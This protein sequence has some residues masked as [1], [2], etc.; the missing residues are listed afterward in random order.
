MLTGKLPFKGDYE[1]AIIYSILNEEP[2]L[3]EEILKSCP[4]PLIRLLEKSLRKDISL[5]TAS[6]SEFKTELEQ[7]NVQTTGIGIKRT[8][9]VNRYFKPAILIPL[10]IIIIIGTAFILRELYRLNKIRWAR[11]EALPKIEELVNMGGPGE[12]FI[13]AFDLAVKAEEFIPNDPKLKQHMKWISGV[14]SIQTQP[15]GARILR[16]PFDK[17]EDDWEFIGLSPVDS[18]R[19]PSYLFRWKFE[20]SGYETMHRL[21]LSTGSFELTNAT[22]LPG[23]QNCILDKKGSL[24]PNMVRIPGTEEIPD[25]LI[26]KYEVSNEQYKQFVDALPVDWPHQ[27]G[28]L[29]VIRMVREITQYL[30]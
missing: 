4:T 29:E 14:I 11:D 3:K 19:M 2:R 28:K 13:E 25:F 9:K 27:H 8:G 5:R 21:F 7:I 24:P 17:S 20:K 18:M 30:E 12:N 16:K 1:Q 22:F 10:G 15:A 23:Y 26:D 6:V